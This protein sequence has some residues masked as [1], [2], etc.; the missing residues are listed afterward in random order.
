MKV[1]NYKEKSQKILVLTKQLNHLISYYD[2]ELN[3]NG[4]I[5]L[6]HGKHFLG[7]L[8]ILRIFIYLGI[9]LDGYDGDF[10]FVDTSKVVNFDFLF[11]LPLPDKVIFNLLKLNEKLKINPNFTL[12]EDG[13]HN[14]FLNLFN[15]D[16]SEWDYSSALSLKGMFYRNTGF[17]KHDIVFNCEKVVDISNIFYKSIFNKKVIFQHPLRYLENMDKAFRGASDIKAI[18]MDLSQS[19]L[20]KGT[21]AFTFEINLP[22]YSN[23]ESQKL[24]IESKVENIIYPNMI[25]SKHREFNLDGFIDLRDHGYLLTSEKMDSSFLSFLTKLDFKTLDSLIFHNALR[26]QE[27]TR[28]VLKIFGFIFENE[29]I[30]N[31]EVI[32]QLI[33]SYQYKCIDFKN[34]SKFEEVFRSDDELDKEKVVVL[35]KIFKT[36]YFKTNYWANKI[37]FDENKEVLINYSLFENVPIGVENWMNGNNKKIMI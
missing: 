2:F 33:N 13:S 30:F 11:H 5:I 25:N 14:L 20:I 26:K 10:N 1:K 32:M 9:L 22:R 7:N 27:I 28:D 24:N 36:D 29:M 3:E 21:D 18:Y 19:K 35:K 34:L 17:Q 6:N 12:L 4:K 16:I 23:D 37:F 15:G 8:N 31:S